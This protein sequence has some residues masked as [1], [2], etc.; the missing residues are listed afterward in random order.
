MENCQTTNEARLLCYY[1]TVLY[2]QPTDD[3]DGDGE[4][5]FCL[6]SVCDVEQGE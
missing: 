3:D 2:I 5:F 4:F 1:C 6:R